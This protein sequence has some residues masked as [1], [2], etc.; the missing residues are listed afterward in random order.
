MDGERLTALTLGIAL[1]QCATVWQP[2][3]HTLQFFYLDYDP[4]VEHMAKL[5]SRTLF[6][7]AIG[8]YLTILFLCAK[9]KKIF[10]L[11]H[12]D[13]IYNVCILYTAQHFI[14]HITQKE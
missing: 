10:E 4:H 6:F 11:L 5:S 13:L 3:C 14:L 8:T 1:A 2:H 7:S 9:L 12:G